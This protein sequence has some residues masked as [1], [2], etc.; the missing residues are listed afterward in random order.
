MTDDFLSNPIRAHVEVMHGGNEDDQSTNVQGGLPVALQVLGL[1]KEEHGG[2]NHGHRDDPE[3]DANEIVRGE[4]LGGGPN[5][6]SRFGSKKNFNL[7][8]EFTFRPNRGR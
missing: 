7:S 6:K 4:E 5:T 1:H 3:S 8:S 2:A